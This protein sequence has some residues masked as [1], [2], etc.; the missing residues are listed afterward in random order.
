[1]KKL[2]MLP[3]ML[4]LMTTTATLSSCN[5]DDVQQVLDLVVNQL[6]QSNDELSN[7]AWMAT[8]STSAIA[9]ST[10]NV[11]LYYDG[12]DENG[13]QFNYTIGSDGSSFEFTFASGTKVA[14]AITEYTARKSMTLRNNSTGTVTAYTYYTG[15]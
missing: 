10:G 6:F 3:I 4:L 14:Y 7:T 5:T 2:L 11:G 15:Q 12:T 9:F 8:D 1:M 13:L